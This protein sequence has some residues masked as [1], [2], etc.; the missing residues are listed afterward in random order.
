LPE[1]EF[2]VGSGAP[3]KQAKEIKTVK[4][5]KFVPNRECSRVCETEKN[6]PTPPTP[7]G[8][9]LA[10]SVIRAVPPV[11]ITNLG[12]TILNF[13][14]FVSQSF[15]IDLNVISRV[16]IGCNFV[17]LLR[18]KLGRGPILKCKLRVIFLLLT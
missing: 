2:Q 1:L 4:I 14:K 12:G 11:I 6:P 10:I 7:I 13:L 9:A 17:I 18:H 5:A 3:N 16:E 15:I 8:L